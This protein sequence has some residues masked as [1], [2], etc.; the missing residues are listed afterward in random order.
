MTHNTSHISKEQLID[1]EEDLEHS[2][3]HLETDNWEDDYEHSP[4]E[5]KEI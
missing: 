1:L 4:D 2:N 3:S 5:D